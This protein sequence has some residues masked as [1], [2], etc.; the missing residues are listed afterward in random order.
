MENISNF[1]RA[2][3]IDE[4]ETFDVTSGLDWAKV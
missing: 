1:D 3:G 2:S 4:N